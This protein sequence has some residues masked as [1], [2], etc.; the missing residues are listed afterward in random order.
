MKRPVTLEE[1]RE[2]GNII[3]RWAVSYLGRDGM[4][5]LFHAA[6]GRYTWATREFAEA[7]AAEFDTEE[8]R[9][10][11]AEVYGEQAPG[12]LRASLVNCWA[13]H[14]DP[15]GIYADEGSNE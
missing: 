10:R 12:T 3:K 11:L 13:G 2:A 7:S 8:N 9:S 5:R 6:Q 4:R 15:V 1:H 14:F